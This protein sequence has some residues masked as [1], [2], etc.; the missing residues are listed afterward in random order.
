MPAAPLDGGRDRLLTL[1][2]G[3]NHTQGLPCARAEGMG[4]TRRP[5]RFVALATRALAEGSV[6]GSCCGRD[7]CILQL[8]WIN[9]ET[10]EEVSFT[11]IRAGHY[12]RDQHLQSTMRRGAV[13][14]P[15]G[16]R[17]IKSRDDEF[18]RAI[19]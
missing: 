3:R 6:N 2:L 9:D 15:S 10:R 13:V 12:G 19:A 16:S 18:A 8:L 11:N 7:T 14:D 4:R 1:A 17:D 5:E